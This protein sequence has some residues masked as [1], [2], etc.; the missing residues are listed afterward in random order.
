MSKIRKKKVK[1]VKLQ[2]NIEFDYVPYETKLKNKKAEY[3]IARNALERIKDY[4]PNVPVLD[5][6]E[7]CR[8]TSRARIKMVRKT[9]GNAERT[10]KP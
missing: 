3:I 8:Y 5:E 9:S 4:L 7:E 10:S 6:I 2:F 1:T